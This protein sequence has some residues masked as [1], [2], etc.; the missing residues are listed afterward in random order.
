MHKVVGNPRSTA[1]IEARPV[2]HYEQ[3]VDATV[4]AARLE[5]CATRIDYGALGGGF[6][7]VRETQ[8]FSQ[9]V[10]IVSAGIGYLAFLLAD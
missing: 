6:R 8:Y 3:N 4:D 2:G 10:Q 7:V 9:Q 1:R 5:A